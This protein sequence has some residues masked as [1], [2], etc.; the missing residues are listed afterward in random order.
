MDMFKKVLN[1]VLVMVAILVVPVVAVSAFHL[2]VKTHYYF[3]DSPKAAIPATK[4]A[5][6]VG[7]L[8]DESLTS[9]KEELGQAVQEKEAAS[10]EKEIRELMK[11][12]KVTDHKTTDYISRVLLSETEARDVDGKK[13]EPLP[14]KTAVRYLPLADTKK[15]PDDTRNWVSVVKAPF[16]AADVI[17]VPAES[18][19]DEEVDAKVM[20]WQQTGKF[21]WEILAVPGK[22]TPIVGFVPPNN[23]WYDIKWGGQCSISING[24]AWTVL[25]NKELPRLSGLSRL[26]FLLAP[27]EPVGRFIVLTIMDKKPD[28]V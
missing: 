26:Q 13:I 8:V 21:Q 7:Q 15:F 28:A 16:T 12:A 6:R 25:N 20:Q 11:Q 24:G 27:E 19:T 5:T 9:A 3:S 22:P 10:I 14:V 17:F 1:F 4:P 2:A 18:V 23:G